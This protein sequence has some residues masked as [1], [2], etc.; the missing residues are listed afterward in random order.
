M[1]ESLPF[2]ANV[3]ENIHGGSCCRVEGRT[4]QGQ[5]RRFAAVV[6]VECADQKR[7]GNELGGDTSPPGSECSG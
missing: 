1:L 5:R 3:P 7:P 4:A 2:V 6:R